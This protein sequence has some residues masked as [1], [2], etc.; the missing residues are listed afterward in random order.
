MAQASTSFM[1]RSQERKPFQLITLRF[2]FCY[3]LNTQGVGASG[4]TLNVPSGH[5]ETAPVGGWIITAT[6]SSGSPI[7]I[8][9]GTSPK[10]VLTAA[11]GLTAG[12]LNDAIF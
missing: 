1:H 6:G 2:S 7:S 4:V 12:T 3:D 8:I 11:T 5:T 9:G 10:P